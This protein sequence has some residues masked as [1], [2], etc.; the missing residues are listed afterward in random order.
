MARS[1][2]MGDAKGYRSSV[3]RD[4]KGERSGTTNSVLGWQ[5]PLTQC[6]GMQRVET[7]AVAI[8]LE[9]GEYRGR[10]GRQRLSVDHGARFGTEKLDINRVIAPCLVEHPNQLGHASEL[11]RKA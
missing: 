8:R 6:S 11:L 10:Q 1:L 5:P 3:R 2:N 9:Y 7:A 4:G